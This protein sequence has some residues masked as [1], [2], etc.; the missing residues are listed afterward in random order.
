MAMEGWGR[1]G[2]SLW[3]EGRLQVAPVNEWH[4]LQSQLLD[5]SCQGQ[6]AMMATA[7]VC[8]A[9]RLF[10][11]IPV[12]CPDPCEPHCWA[13]LGERLLAGEVYVVDVG[14]MFL[15]LCPLPITMG[16]HFPSSAFLQRLPLVACFLGFRVIPPSHPPPPSPPYPRP[17]T[18]KLDSVIPSGEPIC[19]VFPS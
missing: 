4:Q 13:F 16:G 12:P 5:R 9:H 10:V 2:V 8:P 7:P 18:A 6:E 14:G 15:F 3:G 11:P 17:P 1:G 19:A